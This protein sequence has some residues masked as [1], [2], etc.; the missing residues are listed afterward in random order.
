MRVFVAI[1]LPEPVRDALA[2]VQDALPAGRLSDPEQ[3]HITLAFLGEQPDEVVEA[4]HWALTRLSGPPFDLQLAGL[5]TFGDRAPHSVWAGIRDPAALKALQARVLSALHGAGLMLERRRFRPHVTLARL[6]RLAPAEAERL[7]RFLQRF[8]AF[9]SPP[10][11]VADVA[12]WRSTL[13]RSGAV[14]DELARYPLG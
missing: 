6:G 2:A 1:D 14:Y 7:T 3:L 9:P 13:L 4:A 11:R 12:L 8:E 10:F 5:G